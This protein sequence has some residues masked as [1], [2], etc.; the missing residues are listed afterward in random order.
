MAPLTRLEI[1]EERIDTDISIFSFLSDPSNLFNL[2]RLNYDKT[3]N[4]FY[5][6]ECVTMYIY[7]LSLAITTSFRGRYHI[8]EIGISK[9]T[10]TNKRIDISSIF[11][12]TSRGKYKTII[13]IIIRFHVNCFCP[14]LFSFLFSTS[15]DPPFC[16]LLF[17]IYLF[18]YYY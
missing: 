1:R 12:F 18:N 13:R 9:E 11:F 6:L 4:L 3:V 10:T 14:L 7:R 8:L 5:R 17:L 15:N 16:S 2:T